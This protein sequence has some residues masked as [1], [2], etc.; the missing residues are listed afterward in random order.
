V[1]ILTRFYSEGRLTRAPF[2]IPIRG[3]QTRN[4][5]LRMDQEINPPNCLPAF[6]LWVPIFRRRIL[7]KLLN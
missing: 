4:D 7:G 5:R 1:D 6:A 2:T 3:E